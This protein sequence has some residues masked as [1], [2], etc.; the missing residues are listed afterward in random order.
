[1]RGTRQTR[2][3]KALPVA[4]V[5]GDVRL[6]SV[7]SGMTLLELMVACS[8]LMVLA[9]VAIPMER[10]TIKR[11]R[12]QELRYRL[13]E[14]RVAIDRY[15]DAADRNRLQLK[16]GTEGYPPD[17]ETLKNGVNLAATGTTAGANLLSP[18]SGGNAENKI[19]FLRDVP[20]DP[21][22]GNKD[23]TLRSVQ[24]DPDSSSWGGQD[25]FDVHSSSTAI[26]LDG[27]KYSDW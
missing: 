22:T 8:I 15:K 10:V 5:R 13:R 21:M 19:H 11:Y 2:L 17:L 6:R 27:S 9:A 12:E 24:D 1:M 7:S 25:V 20:V 4:T 14:M 3:R 26:A 16:T 18:T 23:W